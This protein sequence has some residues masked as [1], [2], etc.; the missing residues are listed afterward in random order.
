MRSMCFLTHNLGLFVYWNIHFS[1]FSTKFSS[2]N[3]NGIRNFVQWFMTIC[4]PSPASFERVSVVVLRSEWSKILPCSK[5]AH[6]SE[7]V[8][9]LKNTSEI[10]SQFHIK[11][12]NSCLS[13]ILQILLLY[14]N[15]LLTGTVSCKFRNI[16]IYIRISQ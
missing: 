8:A 9:F 16:R 4:P 7:S 3:S 12:L 2:R 10:I 5:P 14:K 11:C 13:K 6:K 15:Y 1:A